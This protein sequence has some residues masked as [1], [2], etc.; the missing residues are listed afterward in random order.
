MNTGDDPVVPD[1]AHGYQ[2]VNW[3]N[4]GE[5]QQQVALD[6]LS[7][8]VTWLLARYPIKRKIVPDRWAFHAWLIEELSALHVGSLVCFDEQDSGLG[9]LQ[10]HE[11]FHHF[12]ERVAAWDG[13]CGTGGDNHRP[14]HRR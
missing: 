10:W 3:R 9:P 6:E 2:P 7:E 14:D 1:E 13:S 5:A 11:R 8:W 4:R 12:R